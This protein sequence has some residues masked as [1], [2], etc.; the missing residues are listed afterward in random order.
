MS[1]FKDTSFYFTLL[2]NGLN[3]EID[4][5]HAERSLEELGLGYSHLDYVITTEKVIS[6]EQVANLIN[7]VY[8]SDLVNNARKL[9]EVDDE[10]SQELDQL[11][12]ENEDLKFRYSVLNDKVSRLEEDRENLVSHTLRLESKNKSLNSDLEERSDINCEQEFNFNERER[13]LK[14]QIQLLTERIDFLNNGVNRNLSLYESEVSKNSEL[15][16]L[17]KVC[18]EEKSVLIKENDGLDKIITELKS[19]KEELT[20]GLSYLRE[21][22]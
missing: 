19:E 11:I 15:S 10:K 6:F 1:E 22:N 7:A 2:R 9:I 18:S 8:D 13:E 16:E 4:Q 14:D 20:K 17:L 5:D 3:S 21:C 12:R